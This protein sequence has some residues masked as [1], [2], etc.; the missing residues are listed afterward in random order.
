VPLVD[1]PGR[2][3]S[4]D[5]SSFTVTADAPGVLT[6]RVHASRWFTSDRPGT[7]LGRTEE[8]WTTVT[9]TQPGPVT[10]KAE[11]FP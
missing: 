6:V 8:G 2:F 7:V 5:P 3:T 4:M 10:V 11:V 9:V 1:G